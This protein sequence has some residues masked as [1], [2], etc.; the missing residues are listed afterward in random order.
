MNR[1]GTINEMTKI[2]ID[3]NGHTETCYFY[4]KNNNLKYDL[5]LSRLWLNRNNVQIVVKEKAIYFDLTD[6]YIKSTESWPKKTTSNIHKINDAAYASWM[7]QTKKQDSGIKVFTAFMTN[8]EKAL[9]LKLNI[10][11]LMLLPEHYC[12]KLQLF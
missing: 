11:S 8:I 12:H 1:P 2:Y 5:I 3:I 4:I 7:K 10:N 6:L 9:H